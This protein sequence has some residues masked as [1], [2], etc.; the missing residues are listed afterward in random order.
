[1]TEKLEAGLGLA[2]GIVAETVAGREA[3]ID[4]L[5]VGQLEEARSS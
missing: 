5:V 3:S 1:M 4:H 2:S